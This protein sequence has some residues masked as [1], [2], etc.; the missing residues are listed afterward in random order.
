MLIDR[1]MFNTLFYRKYSSWSKIIWSRATPWPALREFSGGCPYRATCGLG[2]L[3]AS[4]QGGTAPLSSQ[5]QQASH[6]ASVGCRE[7]EKGTTLQLSWDPQLCRLFNISQM[8]LFTD[9][10]CFCW[11]PWKTVD[12][13][14]S[15]MEPS[16]EKSVGGQGQ[17]IK[18]TPLVKEKNQTCG[19][20][21]LY[22]AKRI[23][24]KQ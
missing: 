13:E 4:V 14:R 12:F 8:K 2:G 18:I 3:A 5:M 6:Y 9:K 1:Y 21:C 23:L 11:K 10:Y 22:T 19:L 15:I 7:A 24:K 20:V 17:V 16:R